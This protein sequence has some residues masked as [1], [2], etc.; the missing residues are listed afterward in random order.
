LI[1]GNDLDAIFNKMSD[2]KILFKNLHKK[3]YNA[4]KL[5]YEKGLTVNELV[6]YTMFRDTKIITNDDEYSEIMLDTFSSDT[7]SAIEILEKKLK[8]RKMIE[9][10]NKIN[11]SAIDEAIEIDKVEE[12]ISNEFF[13]LFSGIELNSI[14]INTDNLLNQELGNK[15]KFKLLGCQYEDINSILT[16]GFAGGNIVI[17]AGRTGMGKSTLKTNFKKHFITKNIGVIDFSPQNGVKLEQARLDSLFTGISFSKIWQRKI[18]D[19]IDKQC[20]RVHQMI[21]DKKMPLW[22]NQ[23][24][25]K[26]DINYIVRKVRQYQKERSD[27]CDWVVFADLADK[28][29]EFRPGKSQWSGVQTGLALMRVYCNLYNFCFVPIVQIGRGAE[30]EKKIKN[31]KPSLK[32]L[33]GSGAWEE[34]PDLIFLLFREKYYDES[35][36]TDIVEI[37]VAKQRNGATQT[38]PKMFIGD[39]CEIRDMNVSSFEQLPMDV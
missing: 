11:K 9:F 31:K 30:E 21:V 27:I 15:E 2:D 1:Q 25:Q 38:F 24:M 33:K 7:I 26:L 29:K 12:K 5:V 19:D 3:I 14:E 18:G 34:E 8:R 16:S 36:D 4:I 35:L 23:E 13:D 17:G 10:S 22:Q 6:S 28:I 32:D 20:N 39:T 37:N